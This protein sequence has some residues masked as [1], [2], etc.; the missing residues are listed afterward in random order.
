MSDPI[1]ETTAS[2]RLPKVTVAIPT[3]KRHDKISEA[4]ASILNQTFG[5]FELL[6]IDNNA[7]NLTQRAVSRFPDSRIRYVQSSAPLTVIESWNKCV[8]LSRGE[9]VHIFADDDRLKPTFLAHSVTVLDAHPAVGFT[10]THANKTDAEWR[11]ARLWG[12]NFPPPGYLRRDDYIRLTLTHACCITLAP[13]VVV[14]RSL[15]ESVGPYR[16]EYGSNT[17]DFNLYL[18]AALV[19]DSFFIDEV[20]VDY[21]LH[22][23]QLT[24]VHWRSPS[25]PTGKIGTYLELLGLAA[26]LVRRPDLLPA[27]FVSERVRYMVSELTDLLRRPFPHL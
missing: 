3:W 5:D 12:Y 16:A 9:Y 21:R 1:A 19:S 27:E 6:I 4:V 2:P 11:V 18:R 23:D 22:P 8:D 7:D 14:R 17:F 20:L 26:Q 13:T 15:Y 24:E 25:A 10:F